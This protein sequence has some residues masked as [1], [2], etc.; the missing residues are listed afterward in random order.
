MT[1]LCQLP[2]FDGDYWPT[3]IEEIIDE[4]N[5]EEEERKKNEVEEAMRIDEVKQEEEETEPK[6]LAVIHLN[7]EYLN[8]ALHARNNGSQKDGIEK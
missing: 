3:I 2:Y 5:R 1:T 6:S 7:I 4:I 8:I